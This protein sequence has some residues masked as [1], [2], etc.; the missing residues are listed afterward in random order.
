MQ[1]EAQDSRGAD[2]VPMYVE[3]ARM[4]AT[5]LCAIYAREVTEIVLFY[6]PTS[7]TLCAVLPLYCI[8]KLF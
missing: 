3:G 7:D 4:A 1:S 2:G 8:R 6:P 5:T